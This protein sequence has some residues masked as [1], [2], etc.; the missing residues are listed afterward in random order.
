MRGLWF[1]FAALLS[2]TAYGDEW[3]L[4]EIA[5]YES[6]DGL[7]RVVVTPKRLES[8]RSYFEDKV[9]NVPNAGA[10]PRNTRNHAKA[11][12]YRRRTR[13]SSWR[14]VARWRLVNEVSPVSALVANDGSVATFDNWHAMGYGDDVVAIYRC[15]GSLVRK[16]ALAR[17]SG[18]R[19]DIGEHTDQPEL[20][21][22]LGPEAAV[23]Q[24]IHRELGG[25]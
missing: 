21:S 19:S 12:L 16:F 6:A 11:A 7:W 2:L 20:W 5:R 3:T 1:A 10:L 22:A 8:Q 23:V 4:P 9:G 14:R 17:H 13:E 15:D 24:A 25:R 18:R